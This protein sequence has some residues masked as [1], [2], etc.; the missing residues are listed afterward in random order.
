MDTMHTRPQLQNLGNAF[1]NRP[2]GPLV[3]LEDLLHFGTA[4]LVFQCGLAK[5]H[6][7][8]MGIEPRNL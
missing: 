2:A 8:L 4:D 3:K 7:F 5:L 1:A 6:L